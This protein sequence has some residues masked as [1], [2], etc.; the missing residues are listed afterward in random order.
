[1][2]F[3]RVDN[4]FIFI[5]PAYEIKERKNEKKKMNKWTNEQMNKTKQWNKMKWIIIIFIFIII[6][7]M[8]MFNY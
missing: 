7:I 1:M 2:S 5:K 6:M 3:D 4:H 8:I